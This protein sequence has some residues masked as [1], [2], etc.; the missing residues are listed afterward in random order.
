MIYLDSDTIF[1]WEGM[2]DSITL[3]WINTATVTATV[4]ETETTPYTFNMLYVAGSNGC[5]RGTYPASA[6]EHLTCGEYLVEVEATEGASVER[7]RRTEIAAFRGF[8]E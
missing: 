2:R 4:W 8:E 5:Y 6:S 1:Y 7:R 3:E